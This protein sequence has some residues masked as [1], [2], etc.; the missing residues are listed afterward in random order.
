MIMADDPGASPT[1][2]PMRGEEKGRVQLEMTGGI[3]GDIGGGPD[4]LYPAF[5]AQQEAAYLAFSG[6]RQMPDPVQIFP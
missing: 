3:G 2:F 6:R 4:R 1:R 5:R